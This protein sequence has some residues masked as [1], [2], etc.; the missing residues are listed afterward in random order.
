MV[1]NGT[2][3]VN[4]SHITLYSF[5]DNWLAAYCG[6]CVV[7]FMKSF[8]LKSKTRFDAATGDVVR[9]AVLVRMRFTTGI[10]NA[11]VSTSAQK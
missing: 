6:I 2:F 3:D 11:P 5:I 9:L 1:H 8:H 7:F 4:V 10:I